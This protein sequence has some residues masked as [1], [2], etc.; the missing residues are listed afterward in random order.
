MILALGPMGAGQ[1]AFGQITM[2]PTEAGAPFSWEGSFGDV[3]SNTGNLLTTV[4]IVS[5]PVRGGGTLDFTLYH[6][7]LT[8]PTSEFGASWHASL[9]VDLSPVLSG[10]KVIGETVT[11]GDGR[12]VSFMYSGTTLVAP[13]GIYDILT[14]VG[15]TK[16]TSR[17]MFSL[18]TRDGRMVWKFNASGRSTSVSDLSGNTTILNRNSTG[19]LIGVTDPS[20][21]S[22]TLTIGSLGF[23]TQ[24][25]DPSGRNWSFNYDSNSNL[26]SVILPPLGSQTFSRSFT[27]NSAHG[28]ITDTD[29]SGGVTTSV[30][31][32]FDRRVGVVDPDGATSSFSFGPTGSTF[33]DPL[34]GVTTHVYSSGRLASTIDPAGATR[35]HYYDSRGDEIQTV[36]EIGGVT[37]RTFD[38]SGDKLTET[39]P[40]GSTKSW[41][42]DILGDV[43]KETDPLGNITT[44]T[45]DST[46]HLLRSINPLGQVR[47]SNIW[48]SFGQLASTTNA[49]GSSTSFTYNAN[50]DIAT[51]IDALGGSTSYTEDV[52][53]RMLTTTDPLGLTESS[54]WDGLGR[55]RA[56]IAPD[57][58]TVTTVFDANG[59]WLLRTNQRGNVTTAQYD[60]RGDQIAVT[61]PLGNTNH[62]QYDLNGRVIA[63][64]DGNGHTTN[65]TYGPTGLLLTKT[66]ADGTTRLWTYDA[67]RE[68][69]S[70]T[71][72][73]GQTT[74]YAYDGIGRLTHVTYPTGSAVTM[75]YDGAG[76]RT[77]MQDGTG[78]TQWIYD[79]AGQ[80]T[81]LASPE[82]TINFGYDPA[83]ENTS[84]GANTVLYDA[85]GRTR[86]IINPFAEETSFT[87]DADGRLTQMTQSNGNVTTY[88]YNLK[89]LVS[90]IHAVTASDSALYDETDSYDPAGDLTGQVINGGSFI[91]NYDADQR[92]IGEGN[93]TGTIGYSYDPVGNRIG[94]IGLGGPIT[95]SYDAVDRLLNAGSTVFAYDADGNPT[96]ITNGSLITQVGYDYENRPVS[97]LLPGGHTAAN[98]FNGLGARVEK[99][100]S[101]GTTV[102]LRLG[103]DPDSPII[104]DSNAI[105]TPG[106]SE[107]RSGASNFYLFN[108]SGALGQITDSSEAATDARIWTAFGELLASTGTNPTPFEFSGQ[109]GAETD[110]DTGFVWFGARLYNPTVGQYLNQVERFRPPSLRGIPIP[111]TNLTSVGDAVLQAYRGTGSTSGK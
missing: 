86:G 100:N 20:G 43:T 32:G 97:M 10:K 67:K 49:I 5:W 111:S 79:A 14:V 110:P 58:T 93:P 28:I 82:G 1:L 89:S 66:L 45:F 101:S 90:S 51:K 91:Y 62:T 26:T 54:E 9:D 59:R 11:Y 81:S 18:Q 2:N 85:L 107:R 44:N 78:T 63:R 42:Y 75:T 33:T 84:W 22:L 109:F 41:V 77:S 60:A 106:I 95:Y 64:I 76:R 61:D 40:L 65:Y 50:G 17:V 105:Y 108:G 52:L 29:P 27:Y 87:R 88:G 16:P 36:D 46:G 94:R 47:I 37:N 69:T 31:D 7:S 39:D 83:G 80:V 13:A 38:T 3:N 35:R 6:N 4:P 103:A 74:D 48:N 70:Y 71:N 30:Y 25:T 55:Q 34:G 98:I 15:K 104:E 96:S 12:T 73:R 53:G 99:L 72:G 56:A 92:I 21:R 57:G 68:V 102:Y 8:Q 23:V 19:D 24:L